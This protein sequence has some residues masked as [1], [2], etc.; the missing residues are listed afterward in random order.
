MITYT[1]YPQKFTKRKT[2]KTKEFSN[3]MECKV[4][5]YRYILVYSICFYIP[6]RNN[7]KYFKVLFTI[8]PTEK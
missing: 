4:N 7:Y 2:T 6:T 3:V 5:I 8:A 1:E